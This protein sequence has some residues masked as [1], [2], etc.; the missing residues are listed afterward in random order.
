MQAGSFTVVVTSTPAAT[1]SATGLPSWAT[2]NTT[3]GQITGTPPDTV[4]S[5]FTVTISANNGITATQILTL[6]VTSAP[7]TIST[8]P[9]STTANQG[10]TAT[11]SVVVAG[12]PPFSYQWRRNG[13]AITG[14]TGS[15]LTLGSVQPASEGVYTVAISNSV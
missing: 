1:F 12:T 11:F 10:Q 15:T 4:G 6:T 13:A 14:A 2:L 8:Q 3:T 7:P 5:P 9:A